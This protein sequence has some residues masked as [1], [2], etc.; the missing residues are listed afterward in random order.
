LKLFFLIVGGIVLMLALRNYH[1]DIEETVVGV[2]LTVVIAIDWMIKSSEI[3]T[4][5]RLDEIE[6]KLDELLESMPER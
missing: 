4:Q 5:A 2:G 3:K 6:E 1:P